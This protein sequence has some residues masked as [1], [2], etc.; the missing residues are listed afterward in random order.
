MSPRKSQASPRGKSF[1]FSSLEEPRGE[2][3]PRAAMLGKVGMLGM[4]HM[5]GL[6]NDAEVDAFELEAD[7]CMAEE[8]LAAKNKSRKRE[9]GPVGGIPR[10][11]RAKPMT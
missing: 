1:V 5:V 10:A 9:R 8:K 7:A 2:L 4:A 3:S 11:A 6:V